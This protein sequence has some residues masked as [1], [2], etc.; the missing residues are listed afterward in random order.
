MFAL[1]I[2]S[3][4]RVVA[5]EPVSLD[6][7]PAVSFAPGEVRIRIRVEPNVTN[8][9]MTVVAESESFYRSS[10]IQLEGDQAPLTTQLQF[11][12]LP[13][14]EYDISAALIGTDGKTTG[15]AHRRINI[16]DVE[17]LQ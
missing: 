2:A 7:T 5:T 3:A 16:V 6:V 17:P 1:A 13:R 15:L 14:G 11:R 8:R 4:A 9:R 12:G 10:T